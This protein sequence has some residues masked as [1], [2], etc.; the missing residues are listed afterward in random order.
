MN[1][2]EILEKISAS[3]YEATNNSETLNTIK[4]I[5]S[6]YCDHTE[7]DALGNLIC[8]VN[9][10]GK[11]HIVLSAHMDKI[12]MKITGIDK[13]TGL[14]SITKSGG[15]DLRTLTAA[16]VKVTGK[17]TVYGCI[18]S[19]PPHLT[20]G[21]RKKVTPIESL[22]IDCGLSYEE[23]SEI[24]SIGDTAEYF[25]PLTCLLGDRVTGAYMDNSAGCTAVIEAVRL[26]KESGTKN[27]ITA[28]F[29]T[30]EET[31]K[32]G[33]QAAFT[34]LQPDTALITDVSFAK[35]P[36]IPEESSAPVSSGAMICISPILQK[37]L[38]DQLIETAKKNNIPYTVEVM[39]A[40]TATDSD[41]AVTAGN[42]IKTGLASIPLLNMHTPVETLSLSDIDAVASLLFNTAKG[43]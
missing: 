13:A 4:E 38:S 29:T 14:L 10:E 15:V 6:P 8:T 43:E 18:T 42:G 20:T 19:T 33:A 12:G 41:V 22:Y 25:S 34:R 31:G 36:G 3:S 11:K 2:K 7:A 1:T 27:R 26:L 37:E 40:R 35:A 5:I 16:R 39:G 28:L 30:R 17:K 21:D 23:I 32:G 24:V 9:S